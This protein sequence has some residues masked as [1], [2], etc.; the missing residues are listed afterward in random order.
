MRVLL[1]APTRT[2]PAHRRVLDSLASELR[3]AGDQVELFPPRGIL[4]PGR[5]ARQFRIRLKRFRPDV[6]HIQYFSR[7]FDGITAVRLP[8][9]LRVVLTHQGASL[10]IMARP[11]SF[12]RLATRADAV[13]AVS[14][15]GLR[16]MIARFPGLAGKSRSIPN[17]VNLNQESETLPERPPSRFIL[18]IGRLAAYKGTDVLLMAFAGLRHARLHL[19]ICGPDQTRGR[20]ARF[21]RSLGID[22]RVHLLGTKSPGCLRSLLKRALF[23]AL[24]SRRE[25]MPMALLEAM[26]AGNAI[27][28]SDLG[29]IR[30]VVRP[31]KDGILVPPA[32]VRRLKDAMEILASDARLRRRLGRSAAIRARK[33]SWHEAAARYRRLYV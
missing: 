25:N 33:F 31:G 9:N 10:D 8:P 3:A 27:V 7:G 26:A 13:T 16:E 32:D 19:I 5:L 14:R 24:P 18:S 6:C 17:G 21:A 28:A 4:S 15:E 11:G 23:F 1:A 2:D 20:T 22:D 12:E 30:E 29:G